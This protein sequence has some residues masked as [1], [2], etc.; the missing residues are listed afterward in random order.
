MG[1]SLPV[2][3]GC[4][5]ERDVQKIFTGGGGIYWIRGLYL[6]VGIY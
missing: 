2:R 4:V 3:Q 6:E 1:G 5:L